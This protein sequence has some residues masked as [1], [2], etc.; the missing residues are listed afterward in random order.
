MYDNAICSSPVSVNLL[1]LS[2]DTRGSAGQWTRA[3]FVEEAT[4]SVH[5]RS[6]RTS[7]LSHAARHFRFPVCSS[8]ANSVSPNH[9]TA[10]APFLLPPSRRRAG[11]RERLARAHGAHV[12]GAPAGAR[13][14]RLRLRLR[15]HLRLERPAWLRPARAT[16]ASATRS[17]RRF[18]R[19]VICTH[20]L[21]LTCL[22]FIVRS[23]SCST[24]QV[25][26]YPKS[27]KSFNEP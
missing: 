19:C 9:S 4:L 14:L 10:C 12:R 15:L 23:F 8:A 24:V 21:K 11:E 1:I 18:Q 7:V 17:E 5:S 25:L 3:V 6:S 20:A 2:K 26:G 13:L 16:R 22:F 27:T